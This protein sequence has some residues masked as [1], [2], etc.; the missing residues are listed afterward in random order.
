MTSETGQSRRLAAI[1][2]STAE[3]IIAV[4]PAGRVTLV[5]PAAERLFSLQAAEAAGRSLAAINVTLGQWLARAQAEAA[6]EP[7]VF[8]LEIHSGHFYSATLSPVQADEAGAGGWVM[9]L[10][11]SS[12][13][14]RAEEW[15]AEAIQSATHDLR[16]PINLMNGALNLLRDSLKNATPEQRECL[17][18]LRSGLDRMG[19][20]VEQ[21]LNLEQV[22]GRT[23]PAL[24]GV[25]LRRVAAQAADEQRLAAEEKG[26]SLSF[27]GPER[28]GRV[29]G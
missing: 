24:A 23:E 19:G 17:A 10:Q 5:N 29:L 8:S 7:L 15:K 13:L 6:A 22:T 26:L 18:M 2:R 4:D 14:R 16:N 9:V 20:L 3:A 25:D 11:D 12:Q 28:A 1:L 21:V 27:S